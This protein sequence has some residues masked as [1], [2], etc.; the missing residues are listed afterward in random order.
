M[1]RKYFAFCPF[2]DGVNLLFSGHNSIGQV[3]LE[4][5]GNYLV[6]LESPPIY[7]LSQKF[8]KYQVGNNQQQKLVFVFSVNFWKFFLLS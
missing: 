5:M 8:E 2:F 6:S 7:R 3:E 1:D 4:L